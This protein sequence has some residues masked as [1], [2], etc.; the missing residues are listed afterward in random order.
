MIRLILIFR[1]CTSP[2]FPKAEPPLYTK[3]DFSQSCAAFE[4]CADSFSKT[5]EECIQ[6]FS[7]AQE[8]FCST[9]SNNIWRKRY[10]Y[11]VVIENM[12]VARDLV[13]NFFNSSFE[14][15]RAMVNLTDSG[16]TDCVY[17][18]ME[19]ISL[20]VCDNTDDEQEFL[21]VQLS[22]GKFIIR[23]LNRNCLNFEEKFVECDYDNDEQWF[24]VTSGTTGKN[25][26]FIMKKNLFPVQ[27]S[28]VVIS[29]INGL[30]VEM[31]DE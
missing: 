11:D 31:M 4:T 14:A 30:G 26:V 18:F 8:L 9:C 27:T 13:G 2:L 3:I 5:K 10:C 28:E 23:D 24:T 20:G 22:N 12:K 16:G 15:F 19:Q 21:F 29:V 7:E 17:N 1:G 6:E 25:E